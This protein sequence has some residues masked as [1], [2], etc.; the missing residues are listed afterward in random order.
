MLNLRI[1]NVT[2]SKLAVYLSF[3]DYPTKDDDIED[4]RV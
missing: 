1:L 2:K 4:L 3:P